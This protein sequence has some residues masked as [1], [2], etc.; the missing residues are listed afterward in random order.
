MLQQPVFPA[1]R[2]NVRVETPESVW[3]YWHFGEYE[4]T[5]QVRNLSLGG[6]FIQTRNQIPVGAKTQLEF[7]V[8]EGHIR[9]DAIVEHIH[10]GR[11]AGLKFLA[12]KNEDRP[13]LAALL[14]RLRHLS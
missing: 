10:P 4:D 7:L 8:Q 9:A 1:R 5:V 11:G 3:V 2:Y 14:N 13:R 12:V 6:L